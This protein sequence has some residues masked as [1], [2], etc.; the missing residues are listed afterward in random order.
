ML[1]TSSP[2]SKAEF[3]VQK[4]GLGRTR[5]PAWPATATWECAGTLVSPA[6]SAGSSPRVCGAPRGTGASPKPE[7]TTANPMPGGAPGPRASFRA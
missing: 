4:E 5:G 2:D 6:G 3:K 7:A 1:G